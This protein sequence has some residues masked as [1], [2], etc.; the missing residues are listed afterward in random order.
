M[1]RPRLTAAQRAALDAL[2]PKRQAFVLAYVGEAAGNGTKAAEIAGYTH[3]RSQAARL[4]PFVSEAIAAFREPAR[5]RKIA[6]IEDLRELWTA[7]AT[8]EEPDGDDGTTPAMRDRLKASDLLGKSLGAFVEKH[9]ITITQPR[10]RE[11]A[12]ERIEALRARLGK[13]GSR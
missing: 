11:E 4:L 12:L 5:E 3:P 9:E 8:G 10:S 1:T 2:P 7:V 13:G 6:T